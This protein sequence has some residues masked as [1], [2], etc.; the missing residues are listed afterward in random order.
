MVYAAS[1]VNDRRYPTVGAFV[2]NA[3]RIAHVKFR[4]RDERNNWQRTMDRYVV[5]RYDEEEGWRLEAGRCAV[6]EL[7]REQ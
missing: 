2:L 7:N 5:F 1:S 6:Q 4:N 3:N